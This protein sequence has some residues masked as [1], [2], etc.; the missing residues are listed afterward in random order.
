VESGTCSSSARLRWA[1][2]AWRLADQVVRAARWV[3]SSLKGFTDR[4]PHAATAA[5]PDRAERRGRRTRRDANVEGRRDN[6]VGGGAVRGGVPGVV[7]VQERRSGAHGWGAADAGRRESSGRQPVA[8]STR[9]AVFADGP[10]PPGVVPIQAVRRR[11]L[12]P[13]GWRLPR[14][15]L[16]S[17][18]AM[19]TTSVAALASAPHW[20]SAR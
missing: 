5:P 18:V 17:M 8:L 10:F 20:R 19:K 4:T 6:G 15:T 9:A 16:A 1:A 11:V 2:V 12:R 13:A 14:M 7:A 3:P